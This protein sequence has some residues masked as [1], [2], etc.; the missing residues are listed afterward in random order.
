LSEGERKVFKSKRKGGLVQQRYLFAVE[1][2]LFSDHVNDS[3]IYIAIL[4]I[5]SVIG[6]DQ[7]IGIREPISFVLREQPDIGFIGSKTGSIRLSGPWGQIS[8]I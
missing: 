5:I 8:E 7:L 6:I 4:H 1:R 2:K 3:D